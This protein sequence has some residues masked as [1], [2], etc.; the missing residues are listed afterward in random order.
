MSTITGNPFELEAMQKFALAVM[1]KKAKAMGLEKGVAFVCV[2]ERGEGMG[3]VY[4]FVVND[5]FTRE[6]DPKIVGDLGT[7]YFGIAMM[8]LA[9]MMSTNG[10]SGV[11]VT[12]KGGESSYRGG[13]IRK[14]DDYTTYMGF[15]GGTEDQDVEIA[16]SGMIMM[17]ADED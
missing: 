13:L 17:F 3:K 5:V 7:N 14:D 2:R 11:N 8:K 6:P 12:I 10:Y 4:F 9:V 16:T 1:V 15:S